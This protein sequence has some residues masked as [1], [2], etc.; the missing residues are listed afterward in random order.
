MIFSAEQI[1][2]MLQ[3]HN[4]DA[5][6]HANTVTTACSLLRSKALLSRADVIAAKLLQTGQYTDKLDQELG[7][8]PDVFIDTVDIHDRANRHN[9]YG[10]VLFVFSPTLLTA[11]GNLQI[12]ITR[13]NPSQ[14]KPQTPSGEKWFCDIDFLTNNFAKGNFQQIIV[15]RNPKASLKLDTNLTHIVLDD[16]QLLTKDGKD[17]FTIAQTALHQAATEGG[18]NIKIDKR[19]CYDGICKCRQAF[20][21]NSK[22]LY[23]FFDPAVGA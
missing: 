13:S 2:K 8:F 19:V 4:V 9:N 16:P 6:Y 3:P 5:F 18:L 15:F 21:S 1:V 22:L 11:S 10:P 23:K 7:I 20:A 12:S 14:W 17:Y